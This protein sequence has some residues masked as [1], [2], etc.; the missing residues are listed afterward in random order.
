MSNIRKAI[1]I[2]LEKRGQR[3]TFAAAEAESC[4]ESHLRKK[5]GKEGEEILKRYA[6]C[7]RALDEEILRALV[8]EEEKEGKDE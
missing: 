1:A 2:I 4:F 8:R 3:G 5:I 6:T 7:K